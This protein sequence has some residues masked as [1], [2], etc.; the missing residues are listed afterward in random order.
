[1][2]TYKNPVKLPPFEVKRVV[3]TLSQTIDWGLFNLKIPN[4]WTQSTGKGIIVLI[5]DTGCPAKIKDGNII[6]HPDL[7]GAVLVSQCKSFID[8]EGI[9]DVQGHSSHCA[10]IVGARNNE[11]GC[12]GYAP[13][14]MIVTYKG[15]DKNGSGSMDQITKALEYAADYLKPDII[16]MSLGSCMPDERMHKA[17][18]RLYNMN[19][20]VVAAGGNGGS[21]EGVNY[22]GEYDE[23]I[24]IAA[25]NQK[26]GIANFSAVGDGIDFAFPG[27]DIYSTYLN[28]GYAKLSGTSMACPAAAGVVALL[29]A[30]HKKQEA[31][32][33]KNDCKTVDQIKEHLRKYSIDVGVS[34]KDDW[35]GWGIVD[36]SKMIETPENE[37]SYSEITPQ[38]I[39]VSRISNWQKVKDWFWFTFARPL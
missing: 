22:P 28:G 19:I 16:S 26:N 24:T 5:I 38:P 36:V 27:V 29:L 23:V 4:T 3:S 13:D 34:G 39:E 32:T 12:V 1:M 25:Y 6:V 21:A 9:E 15:L 37:D 2:K 14:C 31:E 35:F 33:G 30:K 18:K 7:D 10:G 20:P 8:D 17:I 11:I